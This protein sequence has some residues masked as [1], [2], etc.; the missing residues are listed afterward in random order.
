M[1]NNSKLFVKYL[2]NYDDKSQTVY[3]NSVIPNIHNE[4]NNIWNASSGWMMYEKK[5][6][7]IN[8]ETI[9]QENISFILDRMREESVHEN[10]EAEKKE[11]EEK[12]VIEITE[13]IASI[14]DIISI[15]NKYEYNE[16][17]EYNIDFHSIVKIKDEL[18]QL[19]NMV[20]M[21]KLKQNVLDQLL[22]FLQNLHVSSDGT[23][24]YKH[25]VIYGPPGTG[26]TEVAKII[27]RMYSKIGILSK[28]HFIKVTRQ[29]L[30]A[31]YLGQTAIKTSKVIGESL[32]G[33]LFIDE[34]YALASESKD[35]SFS[36]ECLD[37]LCEA[38]SNYKNDWMVIVAGYEQ[39]L[40]DTFFRTNKGLQ[41]R[42][43]WKFTMQPYNAIELHNIFELIVK[44]S[45]WGLASENELQ[46]AW[47]KKYYSSFTSYGRDM[48]QLFTYVKICHSRRIYGLEKELRKKIT[49]DD[50]DNGYK[51]F[52]ENRKEKDKPVIYGLYT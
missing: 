13:H 34:A 41:S 18:M 1:L 22:Y 52:I 50:I 16:N 25:T 20:G 32:G 14:E 35:D 42:F 5:N 7:N 44:S 48:E 4:Y 38:L 49:G 31:G 23:S 12:K 33:V 28:N 10:T 24:D 30:V 40:N 2:D 29:D 51:M 37:T 46:H 9:M 3:T 39:E 17:Y 19:D 43:I 8:D 11:V 45:E 15:I 26:K 47:F 21:K 27:G 6:D 36:K